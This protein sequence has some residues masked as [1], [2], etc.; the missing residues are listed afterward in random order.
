MG[1]MFVN[2]LNA[3]DIEHHLLPNAYQHVRRLIE[4]DCSVN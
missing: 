1:R 4:M 2:V 3:L